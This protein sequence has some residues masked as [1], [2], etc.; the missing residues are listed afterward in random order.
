MQVLFLTEMPAMIG[1]EYD[2]RIV[3]SRAGIKRVQ[4]APQQ[5]VKVGNVCQVCLQNLAILASVPDKLEI[6]TPFSGHALA[7][8][9]YVIQ[10][11][12]G[13]FIWSSGYISK[14]LR[15]AY[16]GR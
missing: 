13:T 5:G 16:H 7:A 3:G 8:F 4:Q 12:G 1:P 11:M 10:I 14:Y 9:R 2:D 15:G 6:S